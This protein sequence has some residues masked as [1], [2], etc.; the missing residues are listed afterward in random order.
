M[1]F[2][3]ILWNPYWHQAPCLLPNSL[4]TSLHLEIFIVIVASPKLPT[5]LQIFGYSENEN[6]VCPSCPGTPTNIYQGSSAPFSRLAA[7]C[8]DNEDSSDAIQ[9]DDLGVT[10]LVGLHACHFIFFISFVFRSLICDTGRYCT[11]I[12]NGLW[13]VL[14]VCFCQSYLVSFCGL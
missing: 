3:D 1:R 10:P 13:S 14:H 4:L 11:R 2:W 8:L 6:L 12:I 5:H 7:V 9:G